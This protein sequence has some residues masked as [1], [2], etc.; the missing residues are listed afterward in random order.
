MPRRTLTILA[1]ALF[2]ALP[3]CANDRAPVKVL[4]ITGDHIPAHNW[5]ETTPFL[6]DFLTKAG[7]SVDVTET[8]AKDLTPANLANYDVLLLNYRDTPNGRPETRWSDEN[9]KAFAN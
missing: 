2:I 4:I 1:A 3:L 9:K 7:L 8:P 5:R 6:K